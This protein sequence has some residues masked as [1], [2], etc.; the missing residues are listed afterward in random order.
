MKIIKK[1][2]TSTTTGTITK[3]LVATDP[4]SVLGAIVEI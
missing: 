2:D 1:T 3:L 4:S